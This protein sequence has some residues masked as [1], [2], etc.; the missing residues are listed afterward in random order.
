MKNLFDESLRE[1]LKQSASPAPTPGG[2][3]VSAVA[4]AFGAAMVA[5]VGNLT[6][7][8]EKYKDVEPEAKELLHKAN[9]VIEE[10]EQL[11]QADIDAFNA[12]MDVYK[13]PKNTEEEKALRAQALQKAA[14]EATEVPL[15]IAEVALKGIEVAKAM[16][17][18]GNKMAI[19]DVGVGAYLGEGALK[20]ALLSVDINLPVIKDA[21]YVKKAEARRDQL[22][23]RAEKV[24]EEALQVLRQRF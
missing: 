5:M 16:A 21:D 11:V 17:S 12:Y 13:M 2:G 20:G 22:I 10:L 1:V 15:A 6:V 7:G 14:I 18:I 4:G 8:K 3:S 24:R 9:K 19:S 23:A